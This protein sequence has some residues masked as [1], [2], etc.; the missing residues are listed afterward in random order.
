MQLIFFETRLSICSL[1][2]AFA[3]GSLAPLSSKY[4]TK[5]FFQ[6]AIDTVFEVG[7]LRSGY[8][9]RSKYLQISL[10]L[11]PS[12]NLLNMGTAELRHKSEHDETLVVL[13]F[14]LNL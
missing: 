11:M 6:T 4:H 9:C 3:R 2:T 14:T 5:H 1:E 10:R 8:L 12:G 7:G 13:S